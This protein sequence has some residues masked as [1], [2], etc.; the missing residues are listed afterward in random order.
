MVGN[1]TVSF[2][3]NPFT[4]A[5]Y[6]ASGKKPPSV[7]TTVFWLVPLEAF[8][9]TIVYILDSRGKTKKVHELGTGHERD[10]NR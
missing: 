8:L 2:S 10:A 4:A 7:T 1:E 3:G 6:V 5:D 9:L